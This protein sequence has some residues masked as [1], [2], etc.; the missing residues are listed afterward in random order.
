MPKGIGRGSWE[1]AIEGTEEGT[2][3]GTGEGEELE[4]ASPLPEYAVSGSYS[5]G[6]QRRARPLGSPCRPRCCR[7][8]TEAVDPFMNRV[9]L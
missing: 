2:E 1:G 9:L 3:E 5:S 8:C 4:R 6:R 7:F